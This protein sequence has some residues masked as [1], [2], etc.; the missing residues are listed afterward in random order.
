MTSAAAVN[1][2]ARA[3]P[4][5]PKM[6]PRKTCAPKVSPGGRLTVFLCISGVKGRKKSDSGH[7]E[8]FS[9]DPPLQRGANFFD[10][11][12]HSRSSGERKEMQKTF[13]VDLGLDSSVQTDKKYDTEACDASCQAR[14]SSGDPIEYLPTRLHQLVRFGFLKKDFRP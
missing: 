2:V 4:K 3:T 1:G 5:I 13:F 11:L 10:H 6:T 12:L 8:A 7:A 9:N 14:D